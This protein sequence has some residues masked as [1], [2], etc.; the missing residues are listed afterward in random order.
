M[1]FIYIIVRMPDKISRGRRSPDNA[2]RA[3]REGNK[4]QEHRVS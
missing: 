4:H 3:D 2:A 1:P